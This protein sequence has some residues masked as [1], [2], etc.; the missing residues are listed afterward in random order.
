MDIHERS[1]GAC[2][3]EITWTYHGHTPGAVINLVLKHISVFPVA[4]LI[5]RRFN[6]DLTS[7]QYIWLSPGPISAICQP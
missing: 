3:M 6:A 7:D 2:T 1:T 5:A 4:P